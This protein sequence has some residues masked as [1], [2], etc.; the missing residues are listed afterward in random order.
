MHG[1]WLA[2]AAAF[3][4]ALLILVADRVSWRIDLVDAPSGHKRH[5]GAVPLAGGL[6]MTCTV[7]LIMP[8][9]LGFSPMYVGLYVGVVLATAVGV[10]DDLWRLSA[11]RRLLAQTLIVWLAFVSIP[12]MRIVELGDLVGLGNIMLPAA[13][14]VVFTLFACI[15][16]M[17][18]VNMIDG[19]DG[20]AGLFAFQVCLALIFLAEG[21][22]DMAII[23]AIVAGAV[24]GFLAFNMR[25]PWRRRARVFMGDG[26]S[27]ALGFVLTW[28]AVALT[29]GRHGSVEPM[30]M[31]WLLALPLLDTLYLIAT[32]LWR[33]T[34]PLN[35]DRRHFHHVLL[36]W[37]LTPG[38][39]NL[40]WN[41]VAVLFI[42]IGMMGHAYGWASV[43]LFIGFLATAVLYFVGL[44]GVWRVL[45]RRDR[46]LALQ[47][48][49]Q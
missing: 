47:G 43:D 23:P 29:Q 30:V 22:G 46:Q 14:S 26:G 34:S 16:V 13:I 39:A 45:T 10:A 11:R 25:A 20:L 37:G 28:C 15:G 40:A 8:W 9:L 3:C 19:L 48:W 6:A 42:A 35:A 4:C 1:F 2:L 17:N 5:E 12:G 31:V 49:E 27:L 38:Q 24:T 33:G 7:V 21:T 44:A 41:A 32:R 36:W 18:A